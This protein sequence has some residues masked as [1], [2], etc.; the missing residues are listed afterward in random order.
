MSSSA[1]KSKAF[2]APRIATNGFIYD[3]PMSITQQLC[4]YIDG[5]NA[6]KQMAQTMKFDDENIKDIYRHIKGTDKSPTNEFLK[7]WGGKYNHSI[8]ELYMVLYSI[9]AYEGLR[10]IKDYVPKEYHLMIPKSRPDFTKMLATS[11]TADKSPKNNNNLTPSTT[12]NS[13]VVSSDNNNTGQDR[14]N[15]SYRSRSELQRNHEPPMT[16][17]KIN[18][19]HDTGLP[20]IDYTE[21]IEGTNNWD[22]RNRLGKGGFGVVYRGVFKMTDVAIKL[23]TY[24]DSD[25]REQAKVQLQQSRNELNCLFR[26]RHDNI[27]PIYGYCITGEKPCL[28]YQLMKGGALYDRLNIN[29]KHPPLTIQQRIDISAG[30]ARGILFLHTLLPNKSLIHCDIKPGNI[31]LD[32]CL[33]PKIGDFGL[34]REGPRDNSYIK[35][36]HVYGTKGYLPP[37]FANLHRLSKHVDTF[38]FGVVLLEMFTGLPSA[39]DNKNFLKDYIKVLLQTRTIEDLIVKGIALKPEDK[40][41]C[42]MGI[43]LGLECIK[44]DPLERPNMEDLVRIFNSKATEY[45]I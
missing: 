30:T 34:A 43:E 26:Y 41:L 13:S 23:M 9:K 5:L 37:E 17:N 22:E 18:K 10:I 27:L 33:Q 24:K 16:E 35:V 7:I 39:R 19:N 28:V 6:W 3:L 21:L 25:G 20:E 38:S 12:T 1:T 45:S 32:Q 11:S 31:L 42:I 40:S 14:N 15:N 8:L 2:S 36:S 29:N 44:D 4:N